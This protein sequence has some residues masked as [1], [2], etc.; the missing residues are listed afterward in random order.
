MGVQRLY[1][2]GNRNCLA[3]RQVSIEDYAEQH[4]V[5]VA[6]KIRYDEAF[7]KAQIMK[8]TVFEYTGGAV[9]EDVKALW[10]NV[11]YALG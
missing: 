4:G 6:A 10:R 8:A 7:T 1:P 2:Q 11:T 3:L 5:K 9:A